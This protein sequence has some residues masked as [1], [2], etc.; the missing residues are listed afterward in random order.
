MLVNLGELPI[1][2]RPMRPVS[3]QPSDQNSQSHRQPVQQSYGTMISLW[4]SFQLLATSGMVVNRTQGDLSFVT[5]SQMAV[6]PTGSRRREARPL[7]VTPSRRQELGSLG[8]QVEPLPE[9]RMQALQREADIAR[10]QAER[11]LALH[12]FEILLGP[13]GAPPVNPHRA[14]NAEVDRRLAADRTLKAIHVDGGLKIIVNSVKQNRNHFSKSCGICQDDFMRLDQGCPASIA[15]CTHWFHM[16]CLENWLTRKANCPTCREAVDEILCADQ[17]I[18]DIDVVTDSQVNPEL[19]ET[20]AS[21]YNS[22]PSNKST[23]QKGTNHKD[24]GPNMSMFQIQP[25]P[26]TG[27]HLTNEQ[28]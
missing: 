3:Q 7:S 5:E 17:P 23:P 9:Q 16:G 26:G 20:R 21:F 27:E 6:S 22:S 14:R 15:R 10:I 8:I 28:R 18:L 1:T 2:D 12:E 11:N 25:T 4:N 24:V 19:Y 13:R